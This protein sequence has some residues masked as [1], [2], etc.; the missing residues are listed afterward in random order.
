[1]PRPVTA[2]IVAVPWSIACKLASERLEWKGSIGMGLTMFFPLWIIMRLLRTQS[3][4]SALRN[5]PLWIICFSLIAPIYL[6]AIGN[7]F[8]GVLYWL[9]CA[10][11][12]AAF[13][14]VV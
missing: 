7:V 6:L 5:I 14:M 9:T 1:M 2:L 8:R 10:T 12:F 11:Y 3:L 13:L 4:A